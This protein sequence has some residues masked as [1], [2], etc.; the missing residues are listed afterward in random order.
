VADEARPTWSRDLLVDTAVELL[1]ERGPAA[2]TVDAVTRA[3]QVS[4]ATLYRQFPSGSE[5]L[6]AAFGQVVPPPKPPPDAGSVADRLIAVLIDLAA[7]V[8]E[9]PLIVTA[10]CWLSVERGGARLEDTMVPD[11]ADGD[12]RRI[13]CQRLLTWCTLALH[14]VLDQAHADGELRTVDRKMAFALLVAPVVVGCADRPRDCAAAAVEAFMVAE[15]S[16]GSPQ[17]S[18]GTV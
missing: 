6:A 16:H 8:H 7:A 10:M 11:G 5:L 2:V 15:V 9:T 12:E 14:Q 1:R 18:R 4:R 17:K 13:L 3:A